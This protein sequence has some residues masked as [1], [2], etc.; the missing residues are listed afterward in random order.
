MQTNFFY[1]SEKIEIALCPN[2][3]DV[4]IYSNADNADV[5]NWNLQYTLKGHDLVVSAIDWSP[6][7]NKIVTCSHDRNAFVWT[8]QDGAWKP[9]LSILRINRAALCCKWSPDGKKF[10]VAS[11]ANVVPVC[12]YDKSN[13]WWVSKMIKKHKSSVLWVAWHPNSQLLATASSDFR[14]RVFSA[15][16]A[17]TDQPVDSI[18]CGNTGKTSFGEVL[19]E[20]DGSNGWVE[21]CAWSPNGFTLAYVGHDSSITFNV[22]DP[23]HP[24]DPKVQTIKESFLPSVVV[25]FLSDNVAVA[26]GHD[27]KP[28]VYQQNKSGGWSNLGSADKEPKEDKKDTGAAAGG[29]QGARALWA[30]SYLYG[31][32]YALLLTFSFI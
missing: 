18:L 2:S 24:T 8:F 31:I 1:P 21:S 7:H 15:F 22:W 14:C 20:F 27:F 25:L 10:A 29:I 17:E 12:E 28:Y 30:V 6:V 26:A 16:N 5:S 23:K 13:D 9:S 32:S 11:G 19:A 3:E 4:I